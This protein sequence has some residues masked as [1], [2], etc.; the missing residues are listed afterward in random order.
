MGNYQ[1]NAEFKAKDLGEVKWK[2]S[3]KQ[4]LEMLL[5]GSPADFTQPFDELAIVLDRVRQAHKQRDEVLGSQQDGE[6]FLYDVRY[7]GPTNFTARLRWGILAGE[8]EHR[9]FSGQG[10]ARRPAPSS[11]RQPRSSATREAPR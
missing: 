1:A 11:S 9:I 3:A 8:W 6:H 10:E 4:V 7:L 5:K 2:Q